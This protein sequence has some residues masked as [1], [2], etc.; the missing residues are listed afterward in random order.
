M[1]IPFE[2]PYTKDDLVQLDQLH[3]EIGIGEQ[4]RVSARRHEIEQT[5]NEEVKRYG[6]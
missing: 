3:D 4:W 6:S 1:R 5:E 2:P